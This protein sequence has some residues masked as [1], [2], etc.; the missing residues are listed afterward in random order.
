MRSARLYS[1]GIGLYGQETHTYAIQ[2]K[3]PSGQTECFREHGSW[4]RLVKVRI[5]SMSGA[6][7]GVVT[8]R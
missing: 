2:T 5:Y 3:R 6:L 8:R 4:W 7:A 1:I